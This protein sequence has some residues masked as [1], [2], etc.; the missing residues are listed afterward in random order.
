[1]R[2]IVATVG[3]DEKLVV[4]SL[5]G[6]GLRQDDRII[7]VYAEP[8]DENARMR[9]ENA[10]KTLCEI[11]RMVAAGVEELPL[12][13]MSLEDDLPRCVRYLREALGDEHVDEV[14]AILA[15]GMRPLIAIVLSALM[16]L[17]RAKRLP[18]RFVF[19]REDG[20]YSFAMDS[21][22]F[23]P[24][25]IGRREAELLSLIAGME[26]RLRREIVEEARRRLRVAES[27]VY[28]M[29]ASLRDK[30]LV[31]IDEELRIRLTPLGRA[32]LILG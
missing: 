14:T 24:P 9:V 4:R 27:F 25:E 19:S 23:C 12:S 11:V 15:G 6:L 5:L 16:L 21:R 1:M 31:D 22:Y 17:A 29:L 20:I 7:L 3:F 30:G 28:R 10:V 18:V 32:M 26:G 8:R 2:V 13:V